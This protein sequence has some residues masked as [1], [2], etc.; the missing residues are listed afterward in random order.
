MVSLGSLYSLRMLGL[1]MVL[2]ILALYSDDY[3]GAS[4]LL[5]GITLGVYV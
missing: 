3:N 2:P 1:F 4:P 5:I